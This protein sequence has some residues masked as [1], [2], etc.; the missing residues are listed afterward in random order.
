VVFGVGWG[1]IILG[2]NHGG[3]TYPRG[4]SKNFAIYFEFESALEFFRTANYVIN[5]PFILRGY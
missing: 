5:S 1:N 2:E 3:K 4:V